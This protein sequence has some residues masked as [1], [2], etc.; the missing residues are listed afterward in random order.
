MPGK[1]RI[2]VRDALDGDVDNVDAAVRRALYAICTELDEHA[3]RM[4]TAHAN[5][6]IQMETQVTRLEKMMT[7]VIALLISTAVTVLLALGTALLNTVV[8]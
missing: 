7:K 8:G 3:E 4:D 6:L 2:A 5:I 1:T